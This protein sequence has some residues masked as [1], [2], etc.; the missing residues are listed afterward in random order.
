MWVFFG[1]EYGFVGSEINLLL[2][3]CFISLDLQYGP[4]GD[5]GIWGLGYIPVLCYFYFNI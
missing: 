4:C 5:L 1:S 2:Y 3:E